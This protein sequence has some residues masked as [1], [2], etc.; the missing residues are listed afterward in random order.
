[1]YGIVYRVLDGLIHWS[2]FNSSFHVQYVLGMLI[3]FLKV[4]IRSIGIGIYFLFILGGLK[5]T[6]VIE[7]RV[8]NGE[9]NTLNT[10]VSDTQE[11]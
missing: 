5:A 6:W 11:H 8:E 1:M 7:A 4:L 9:L 3:M 2:L 10:S